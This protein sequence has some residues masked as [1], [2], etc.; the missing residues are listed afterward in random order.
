VFDKV[1]AAIT[2]QVGSF[3]E[4]IL[5]D[6]N[7]K[8][9]TVKHVSEFCT[10]N[11]ISVKILI[12]TIPGVAT[13]R[14]MGILEA[15]TDIAVFIDDDNELTADYLKKGINFL[16]NKSNV[17][18]LV[19]KGVLPSNIDLSDIELNYRQLKHYAVG[20]ITNTTKSILDKDFVWSAGMFFRV[21]T[22]QI[23][24]N[25][26]LSLVC[27]SSNGI[28]AGEDTE[29]FYWLKIKRLDV[30]FNTS[31]N[32]IHHID[33]KRLNREYFSQ[34]RN[35][36]KA[37]GETL[38]K[39]YG[40]IL[41]FSSAQHNLKIKYSFYDLRRFTFSFIN[42]IIFPKQIILFIKILRTRVI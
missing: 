42:M 1:L 7:S 16:Q 6:N 41:R 30:W 17:H 29:L 14:K 18:M 19:C 38:N 4:L 10:R 24:F 15:N 8:D 40:N 33:Y 25:Q 23:F 27:G 9:D 31:I 22:L 21:R 11:K 3:D 13:S 34:L 37:T 36:Q 12:N 5:V 26:G 39:T 32:F 28:M 20:Q 2:R 35:T